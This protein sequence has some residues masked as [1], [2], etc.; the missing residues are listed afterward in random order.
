[1]AM[2]GLFMTFM[3]V[4]AILSLLKLAG[5]LAILV[6]LPALTLGY[7]VATHEALSGR[8]PMPTLL[9]A[10]FRA[11]KERLR[12]MMVL[13]GLYALG[14]LGVMG[15]SA[16]AD[17]GEFAR[18]YLF[19]SG[20]DKDV[21][22]RPGVLAAAYLALAAYLPLSFA[23]WHAPALVHWH[24]LSPAKSLFFSFVAC[25]RNLKALTVYGLC[26][27]LI[28]VSAGTAASLV[29]ALAGSPALTGALMLPLVLTIAT[30]FFCSLFFT[31]HE[32]FISEP[33]NESDK[34]SP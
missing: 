16:V 30:M 17:G 18:L 11:G 9:V 2:L 3:A 29:G 25:W 28:T 14:F 34:E 13:G 33:A 6:L 20:E 4:F 31:F 24:G 23:F 15:L 10:A 1:M 26:W 32:S 19:G 8:F 27:F 12:H 21:M 7:M 5:T 22:A